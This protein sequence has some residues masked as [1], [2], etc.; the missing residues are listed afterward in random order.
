[1]KTNKRQTAY[2]KESLESFTLAMRAT[3][4]AYRMP[5]SDRKRPWN[6]LP[7]SGAWEEWVNAGFGTLLVNGNSGNTEIPLVSFL[8]VKLLQKSMEQD[9]PVLHFF[10]SHIIE[11]KD[12]T[13]CHLVRSLTIQLSTFYDFDLE[14]TSQ[15]RQ[16][17]PNTTLELCRLFSDLVEQL[18]RGSILLI[19]IDGIT[20][21][22][23]QNR[24]ETSSVVIQLHKIAQCAKRT[25]RLVITAQSQSPYVA[26]I[27]QGESEG[28]D[29]SENQGMGKWRGWAILNMPEE[30]RLEHLDSEEP[31][32]QTKTKEDSTIFNVGSTQA[33]VVIQVLDPLLPIPQTW[34][35]P[36]QLLFPP[37]SAIGYLSAGTTGLANTQN[38]CYMNAVLQCMS[39][40]IPLSQYFLEGSYK[41]H[42][43]VD[44][45]IPSIP[46]G[47]LAK[48]FATTL[49]T[50]WRGK[51]THF[52]PQTIRVYLLASNIDRTLRLT[53]S[54]NAALTLRPQYDGN[55][56]HDM[57]EFLDFLL[58][59]LHEELNINT[60]TEKP[61]DPE[62][63]Q[64]GSQE[65][66][67]VEKSPALLWSQYIN[68]NFSVISS[69]FHG[70]SGSW[71]S[72]QKCKNRSCSYSAFTYLSLP[73]PQASKKS[74]G[75]TFLQ[76]LEE[77]LKEEQL[78]Q[79]IGWHCSKCGTS[80]VATKK[81]FISRLP[82]ILVTELKRLIFQKGQTIK[83]KTWITFP[84]EIDLTNYV[85]ISE[86]D[87][88]VQPSMGKPTSS[89]I[90]DLY[91][92]CNHD[93]HA[94]KGHYT[95]YIRRLDKPG[96]NCFNDKEVT[97]LDERRLVVS[98][99]HDS[100]FIES[101]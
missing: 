9:V 94:F 10:C 87:E 61:D 48:A 92:V 53:V 13:P 17:M 97:P 78:T 99:I 101:Y 89:F 69:L 62:G 1:M 20:H 31:K 52:M 12:R 11:A 98:P 84:H 54:Q 85:H 81:L 38:T 5:S 39:G 2:S 43:Q 73:L 37:F 4:R 49:K 25:I 42:V 24:E 55:E 75:F 64:G 19:V 18:P 83:I 46:A 82:P 14:T 76:V 77:F 72:C 30:G 34:W 22:E 67:P 65:E 58:S 90:Y 100:H 56:Q 63:S 21:L 66:A 28:G 33:E 93:G 68:A 71:L 70:Q 29:D 95:A 6:I 8:T 45:T 74:K 80:Q 40:I 35:P 16:A 41:S 57:T 32:L 51:C 47:L 7:Q 3:R 50:I 60:P 91:A 23:N 79:E 86:E 44:K 26:G 59:R 15:I 88:T 36:H 27:L 96:W